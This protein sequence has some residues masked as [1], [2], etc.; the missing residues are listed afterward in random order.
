MACVSKVPINNG[1]EQ[2][3]SLKKLGKSS[4]DLCAARRLTNSFG[5]PTLIEPNACCRQ[6]D[7]LR[8][9]DRHLELGACRHGAHIPIRK[10][11]PRIEASPEA[12]GIL[13]G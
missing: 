2:Q 4:V 7:G 6:Y 11:Q 8:T 10:A 1:G 9:A 12:K 13:Q 3:S 5:S